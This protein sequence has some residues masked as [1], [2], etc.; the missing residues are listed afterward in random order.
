MHGR[1]ARHA[2]VESDQQIEGLRASHLA[3]DQAFG[4]HTQG[5]AHEITQG[6]LPRPLRTR[7]TSLHRNV[8]PVSQPQLEDFLAGDNAARTRELPR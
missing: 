7:R 6:N 2:C 3:D 8:V 5:L 1:H 4:A